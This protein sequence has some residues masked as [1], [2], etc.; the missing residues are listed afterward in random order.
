MHKK[1]QVKTSKNKDKVFVF[2]M[3]FFMER[4]HF[5]RIKQPK[6]FPLANILKLYINDYHSVH[7]NGEFK[8][9]SK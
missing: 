8:N 6:C 1:V 3:S 4:S 7:N 5:S 2:H 9:Q